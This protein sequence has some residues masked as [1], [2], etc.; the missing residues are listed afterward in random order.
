M[1]VAGGAGVYFAA[2][3]ALGKIDF[4]AKVHPAWKPAVAGATG[5]AVAGVAGFLTKSWLIFLGGSAIPVVMGL[6]GLVKASKGATST[7]Q[8]AVTTEQGQTTMK[9][10]GDHLTVGEARS[11]P[12]G[13]EVYDPST[14]QTITIADAQQL[15]NVGGFPLAVR[16]QGGFT[17]PT[18]YSS[19]VEGL[20]LGVRSSVGSP[21]GSQWAADMTQGF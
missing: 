11:L 21:I 8:V 1:A 13:S 9:G 15:T 14:G 20:P 5:V 10:I 7:K 4:F 3:L 17:D 19:A 18:G 12:V 6:V 16:G 2:E